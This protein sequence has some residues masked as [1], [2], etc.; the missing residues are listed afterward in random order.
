[1]KSSRL[2][3]GLLLVAVTPSVVWAASIVK[4]DLLPDDSVD[5]PGDRL[6][7]DVFVYPKEESI[8]IEVRAFLVDP[9]DGAR[10]F[11]VKS[12]NAERRDEQ[13]NF[14][15]VKS[16]EPAKDRSVI[17]E[18]V[19][20]PYADLS[21]PLGDHLFGYDVRALHQGIVTSVRGTRLTRLRITENPRA[22]ERT[23]TRTVYKM[24][25][26]ERVVT[27]LI[28]RN[29]ETE[30]VS[31][32]ETVMRPVPEE[33]MSTVHIN[34]PGGFQRSELGIP[35]ANIED[36]VESQLN[37]LRHR[38]WVPLKKRAI[39]FATNRN[40]AD[41]EARSAKRFGDKVSSDLTYGTTLVNIPVEQHER[42][43][44]ERPRWWQRNDPNRFFLIDTL[45]TLQREQ[46][47]DIVGKPLAEQKRDVL[48][49]V[50]GFNNTFE[51]VSL[52]MAQ[53]VHDIRFRGTPVVFSWPSEG[54]GNLLAYQRDEQKA[55]ASHD[56]LAEVLISLVQS[57][58]VAGENPGK[59][60]L[61]AH[62]MGNRVL[63]HALMVVRQQLQPGVKPFG[64]V[65]L[66]APDI[67]ART[68]VALYP[69]I[70]KTSDSVSLYFCSED[71]ALKVARI[72]H[73][74]IRVGQRPLFMQALIN[75]DADNANTSILGHDYFVSR[76]ELLIDLELLI[77]RSLP[78]SQR[79]TLRPALGLVGH[80]YWK[81]P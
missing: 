56:A 7:V 50:H 35:V 33:H 28:V 72:I 19:T 80:Q 36:P 53:L 46:F 22:E 68:F 26:E 44:L 10:T 37:E 34:V 23:I 6:T 5:P 9:K 13:G 67:D 14:L 60:H 64:H 8:Q 2:I 3:A 74:D 63:A 12:K 61:I 30:E 41:P 18:A 81:F 17:A 59:I 32:T 4:L 51:F 55:A 16:F 57:T 58:H 21:V 11:P 20:I 1:M 39:H 43:D 71:S 15:L 54:K 40:I 45:S 69:A 62:S 25:A 38:P 70:E 42:G 65:I 52:R 76:S 78:P 66:A 49:F 47:L 77:R 24:E 27:A 31:V 29:G 48:L 75:I 73:Q 79:P